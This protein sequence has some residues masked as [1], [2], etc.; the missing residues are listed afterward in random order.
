MIRYKDNRIKNEWLDLDNIHPKIRQIIN[1]VEFYINLEEPDYSGPMITCLNRTQE[2]QDAIYSDDPNYQKKPRISVHQ[3]KPC[4]GVDIR[5]SDMPNGLA[6]K[7]TQIIRQI[8]YDKNRPDMESVKYG[9]DRHK[10]HIHIQVYI[11]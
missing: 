6:Y 11:N 1:L 10:T 9:D 4:R 7:V 5:I 2:E 3:T 8:T